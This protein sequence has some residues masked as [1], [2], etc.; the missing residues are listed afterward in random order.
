[1]E[2]ARVGL[3]TKGCDGVLKYVRGTI[4]RLKGDVF[5]VRQVIDNLLSNAVKYTLEGQITV[6]AGLR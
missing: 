3:G 1:M 2:V 4:P 6:T 5:R